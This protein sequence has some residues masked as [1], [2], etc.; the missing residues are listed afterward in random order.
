MANSVDSASAVLVV[1]D[2]VE[3]AKLIVDILS[4]S[5]TTKILT[6]HNGQEAMDLIKKIQNEGQYYLD[7]IVSDI[8][9][10]GMSG[11][12]FLLELVSIG[13]YSPVIF[14]SGYADL[15]ST[16][17]ALRLSAFDYM[18]KPINPD[19]L[20]E[21]VRIS[22]SKGKRIR[23]ITKNFGSLQVANL[24]SSASE[25]EKKS[26][27][28]VIDDMQKQWRMSYLLGLRNSKLG[29]K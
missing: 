9:M 28:A 20:I 27:S 7:T 2:E 8:K 5:S 13:V 4:E 15:D 3:S 22:V 17:H 18:T 14:V 21:S 1:D 16:L 11:H 26:M 25:E 6:A 24:A 10:P 29:G 12:E 23:S 19:H